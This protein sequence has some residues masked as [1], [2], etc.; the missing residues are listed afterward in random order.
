MEELNVLVVRA[1]DGDLDAYGLI[2]RRFQDMA[3]GCGYSLLGDFHLAEDAAQEAFIEAYRDLS[4]LREPAAFPGWFRRIVFKHC[5][6]LTRRK[7]I[8]TVPLEAAA[9]I[10]SRDP[11]PDE[12]AEEREM[13]DK[14]LEA[15]Q[16]LPENERMVTTLFY[17]N[18]YSQKEIAE[19]LNVRVTTVKNRLHT[20]RKRLKERMMHMVADELKSY[21]LSPEFPER[22]RLLLELPHPLDI[23]GHP[24]HQMGQEFRSCF[25]DFEGVLLDE[26]YDRSLSLLRPDHF[27]NYVYEVDGQNILRPE[28]TSQMMDFWLRNG[29]GPGKWMTVGRVFRKGHQASE[30]LLEVHHQAEVL[31][32]EEGLD[33]SRF[34]ETIRK[35]ASKLLPGIPCRES[36]PMQHSIVSYGMHYEA[37]WRDRWLHIAA[38]GMVADEWI[39]KAGLDPERYGAIS[40]AFGLERCAQIRY[41]LDDARKLW[42]PPYVPA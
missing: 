36:T 6:R 33:K 27:A 1:R 31:W 3:Y 14:V 42:Q 19:F 39:A 30:T 40:F 11:G 13:K 34:A 35:V 20:S 22:I 23:E 25:P 21:P 26:V 28:L 8:S 10:A 17:I 4:K 5:D 9:E 38:G 12:M 16:A 7:R 2:V 15:I 41:D 24:V 29:G 37:L 32:C 18:G